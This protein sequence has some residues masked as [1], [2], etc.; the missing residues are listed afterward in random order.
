MGT[1]I[2]RRLGRADYASTWHAMQDFTSG[3]ATDTEDELWWV[4]HPPVY[5][6]GLAGRD[7]HLPRG[8]TPIPVIRTDRGGQ[9]TYHGPGQIVLYPLLDLARRKLGIRSFVRML[10][11]CVIDLLGE[12]RVAARGRIDA[13][14]VYVADAKI[15]ALGLRVRRGCCYHGLALNVDMDL[16]PFLAIDPCGYRGMPVTSTARLGIAAT[17]EELGV[18][19]VDILLARLRSTA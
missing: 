6:V 1:V 4:E 5:T 16:D 3:R 15:A 2:V 13:P 8:A 12:Y 17:M 19:L 10:E 18:R 7:A 9:I 14:G 11:G